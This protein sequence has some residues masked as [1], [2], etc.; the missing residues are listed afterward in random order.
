ML[1][2]ETL[3]L[4]GIGLDRAIAYGHTWSPIHELIPENPL[5]HGH[6]ISI[7]MAFSATLVNNRKLITDAENCRILDWFSRAGLSTDYHQFDEKILARAT[8][9]LFL[10]LRREMGYSG[11]QFQAQLDP[12]SFSMLF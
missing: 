8:V 4:H 11:Q 3:N 7:D 6:T 10:S 9:S 5:R 2:L 12:V 1:K